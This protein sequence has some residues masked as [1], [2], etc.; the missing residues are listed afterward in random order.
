MRSGSGTARRAAG[1]GGAAAAGPWSAACLGQAQWHLRWGLNW[2]RAAHG[3]A[4]SVRS[5]VVLLTAR[6]GP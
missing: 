6:R 3:V 5:V 2:N 1:G 4:D